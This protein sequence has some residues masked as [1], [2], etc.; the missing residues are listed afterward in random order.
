MGELLLPQPA[1]NTMN[2]L[3]SVCLAL[4]SLVVV[5]EAIPVIENPY[6]SILINRND[7]GHSFDLGVGRQNQNL[8]IT[9]PPALC[10][11]PWDEYLLPEILW[12]CHSLPGLPGL[13]TWLPLRC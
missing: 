4:I 1:V 6:L 10:W 13:Q 9:G 12:A 7:V 8:V 2:I 3:Y 5:S 11:F